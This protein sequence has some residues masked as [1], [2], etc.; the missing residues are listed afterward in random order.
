MVVV[1]GACPGEAFTAPNAWLSTVITS[2][3][4]C[5]EKL[6]VVGSF[7]PPPHETRAAAAIAIDTFLN[8]LPPTRH[9]ARCPGGASR[10]R[11]SG[12]G[13]ARAPLPHPL[14][15]SLRGVTSRLV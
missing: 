1:C 14:A 12:R 8:I 11:L 3:E 10:K 2:A 9:L 4:S 13:R 5:I 15:A 7:Q 6:P